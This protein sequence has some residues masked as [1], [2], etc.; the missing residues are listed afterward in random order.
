MTY[1]EPHNKGMHPTGQ[2]GGR[3]VMPEPLPSW[4]ITA[5]SGCPRQPSAAGHKSGDKWRVTLRQAQ[6]RLS[7]EQGAAKANL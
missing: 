7:D 4:R 1:T 5:K 2:N 3:R 6:G